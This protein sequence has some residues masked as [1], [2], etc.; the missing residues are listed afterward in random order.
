MIDV[1]LLIQIY[2]ASVDEI[3]PVLLLLFIPFAWFYYERMNGYYALVYFAYP[4]I[5][6][7][8]ESEWDFRL[9][10]CIS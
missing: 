7:H 9:I 3:M 8:F 6:I 1:K 5:K 2:K 10:Y 4:I